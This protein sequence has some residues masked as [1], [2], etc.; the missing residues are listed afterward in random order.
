MAEARRGGRAGTGARPVRGVEPE[1]RSD[2]IH[3]R[4]AEAFVRELLKDFESGGRE[5][6]AEVR[7][8][9]PQDYLRIV[10]AILPK[11]L[12]GADGGSTVAEIRRILVR[13]GD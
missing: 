11:A 2:G 10:A 5:A 6:I 13:P 3:S 1:A 7:T 12:S 4:L 8:E 9:R